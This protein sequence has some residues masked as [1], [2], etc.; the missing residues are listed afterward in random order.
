MRASTKYI[1]VKIPDLPL[2]LVLAGFGDT[3][4][5]AERTGLTRGLTIH[6]VDGLDADAISELMRDF[7]WHFGIR[8]EGFDARLDELAKP[9]GG[10]LRHLHFAK[11]VLLEEVLRREGDLA[12]VGWARSGRKP[13]EVCRGRACPDA[14]PGSG[15]AR[16]PPRPERQR[17]AAPVPGFPPAPQD[18][19]GLVLHGAGIPVKVPAPERFAVHKLLVAARGRPDTAECVKARKDVE[20]AAFLVR[21]LAGDRPSELQDAWEE[22]RALGPAWRKAADQGR[23]DLPPDVRNILPVPDIPGPPRAGDDDDAGLSF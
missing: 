7:C 5:A 13:G 12:S 3:T 23:Q 2:S 17:P 16:P 21:V 1:G 4:V 11:Q 15:P 8:P 14:R 19:E 22:M 18:I 6:E 9:C 10:W 20:Q